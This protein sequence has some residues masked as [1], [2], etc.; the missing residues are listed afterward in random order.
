LRY[1]YISDLLSYKKMRTKAILLIFVLLLLN[2]ITESVQADTP[3]LGLPTLSSTTA[4]KAVVELGRQ[5]FEDRRLSADGSVAC[6]TCHDARLAFTDGLA[7]SKGFRQQ[8]GTRNAP[9]LFNVSYQQSLFWDGRVDSLESQARAPLTN[10]LEHAFS[11]VDD[12]LV[13]IRSHPEYAALFRQAFD[14]PLGGITIDQAASALSAFERTLMSGYSPFDRFSYGHD[15]AAMTPAA[16]RGLEIFTQRAH[17]NACHTIQETSALFTD[18][19]FHMTPL[20]LSPAVTTHLRT[21]ANTVVNAKQHSALEKLIASDREVA[22]LGRFVVTLD[23]NDIGKFK[24][25]SLRNVA[26]TA[27]YMHDGSIATLEEAVQLELYGRDTSLRYPIALTQNEQQ[28][29]IKFLRALTGPNAA[30]EHPP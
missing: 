9:S 13:A 17:C 27:P 30:T 10:A 21:L 26:K 2:T 4:D 24:T 12:Y 5:L 14:V 19:D 7:R 29:L 22:S 18:G 8:I 16:I 23:P 28:D 15:K 25:P 1:R 20:G 11:S 6:A 3:T